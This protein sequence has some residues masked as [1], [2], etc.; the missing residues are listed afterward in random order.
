VL[1]RLACLGVTNVFA[2][3]RLLPMSS[4][5]KDA[6]IL[7][8]RHQ[9]SV[10]QRQLG[11]DRVRFTPGD[12]ALLAALL[13]RLPRDVLNRLHLVVR[14]D[15]VLR[16]HRDVVARRHAR[17]SRPRHPGRPRVVRSVRVLV[18]RL[19]REN[20][21]W[22][23]RRVHGELLVLGIMP[24]DTGINWDEVIFK[25]LVMKGVYGREM[26]ETWYKM[27]AMLQSGLDVRPVLTHKFPIAEFQKGFEIMRSGNCGKVVLEWA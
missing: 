26:F 16:W 15:T 12:R 2:L 19:V 21:G 25:G 17:R 23:Y 4:R 14:P 20:P 7:A 6:E 22:G 3:L 8:L 1:L 13:H 27:T 5:D 24:Q 9:L 18:L 11:P 10:L